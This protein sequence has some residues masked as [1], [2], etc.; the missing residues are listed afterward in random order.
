[1]AGI[2]KNIA[3]IIVNILM[4]VVFIILILII[5]AKVSMLVNN[6]SYFEA[7][8]Y[9]FFNVATGSME[10][11]ISQ[12]DIIVVEKAD[13][14]EVGDIVTF[15]KDGNF[16]TH[17]IVLITEDLVTTKGD[18]NNTSDVSI[19]KDLIIGKVTK[20]Y[21]SAGI[22]QKIFTTPQIIVAIFITL[23]LFDFAFSYK[24]NKKIEEV[25]IEP[26]KIIKEKKPKKVVVEEEEDEEE[27]EPAPVV[28]KKKKEPKVSKRQ[29]LITTD[30]SDEDT[31][32]L[33]KKIRKIKQDKSKELTP[34]EE[35]TIRL[36]LT[37]MQKAVEDKIN[38]E[39]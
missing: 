3:K 34:E 19:K 23:I 26:Q 14:Y 21:S 6:K 25:E 13:N 12:N 16:I 32:R 38:K 27:E 18:A 30:F 5:I 10:P 11:A 2:A 20:I 35:Y 24:G 8:G 36:D 17:R 7:F 15:E 37:G 9:S 31:V 4:T 22:W 1:M 28:K 39:E 33:Y 29:K